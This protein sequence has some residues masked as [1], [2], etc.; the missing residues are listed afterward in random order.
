MSLAELLPEVS[1][2]VAEGPVGGA[3]SLWN[4]LRKACAEVKKSPEVLDGLDCTDIFEFLLRLCDEKSAHRKQAV[5]AVGVLTCSERGLD[6]M[7]KASGKTRL[8]LW[9]LPPGG[10]KADDLSPPQFAIEL[11]LAGCPADELLAPPED[12]VAAAAFSRELK[13]NLKD[14]AKFTSSTVGKAI[15][16]ADLPLDADD[17]KKRVLQ[18]AQPGFKGSGG[19]QVV[20]EVVNGMPKASQASGVKF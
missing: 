5:T 4:K 9:K 2:V 1:K 8:Q 18:G 14:D 13:E 16:A 15:M 17:S 3:T 20:V 19:K 6:T 12:V 11:I 10:G 7:L